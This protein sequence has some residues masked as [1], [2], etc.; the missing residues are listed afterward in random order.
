[1]LNTKPAL[2]PR[3]SVAPLRRFRVRMDK[4]AFDQFTTQMLKFAAAFA[5]ENRSRQR[6]PDPYDI[7]FVFLRDNIMLV[8]S[9]DTEKNESGLKYS[10]DFSARPDRPAS[11][12]PPENVNVLVEGL[13][14]FLA[15]V[16]GAVLTEI[17]SPNR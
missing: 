3:D 12:P 5:F 13:K 17:A 8:G 2:G 1:M 10:V 16:E 11:S 6:T 14:K 7:F 15:P 4:S 9:N